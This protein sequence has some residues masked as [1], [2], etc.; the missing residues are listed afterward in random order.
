M[1]KAGSAQQEADT[2]WCVTLFA[3]TLIPLVFLG[4]E[5]FRAALAYQF[6]FVCCP[7]KLSLSGHH[8]LLKKQQRG[9]LLLLWTL[10]PEPP[11]GSVCDS[12]EFI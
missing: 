12:G 3:R 11:A 1:D 8:G 7:A 5:V 9:C 10:C 4:Q 2:T 6:V